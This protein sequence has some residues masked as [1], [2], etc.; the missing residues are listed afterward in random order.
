MD[1]TENIETWRVVDKWWTAEPEE[2]VYWALQSPTGERCTV[3]FNP[4]TK[5]F[6]LVEE[7][8]GGE[9]ASATS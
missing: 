2:M 3:M 9:G 1:M 7:T 8:T 4:R 6:R 5:G